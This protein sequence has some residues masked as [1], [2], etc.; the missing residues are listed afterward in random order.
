MTD[1]KKHKEMDIKY[2]DERIRFYEKNAKLNRRLYLIS[3]SVIIILAALTPILAAIELGH[4]TLTIKYT[5]LSSTLLAIF[6]GLTK[7]FRFEKQWHRYRTT[8]NQLGS[9][10]RK[11]KSGINEYNTDNR[12]K[13]LLE[14]CEKIIESEQSTWQNSLLLK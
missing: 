4:T 7:V 11:F 1:Y 8:S 5:L 3:Q 6:E 10:Y 14:K 9:E 2:L 13:I 12:M